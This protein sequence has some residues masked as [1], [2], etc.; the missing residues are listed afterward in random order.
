[1]ENVT[2]AS[3]KEALAEKTVGDYPKHRGI[4]FYHQYPADIKLFAQMGFK[5]LRISIAWPAS[6]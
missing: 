3:L 6:A 2:K 4:D 5:A 1:M